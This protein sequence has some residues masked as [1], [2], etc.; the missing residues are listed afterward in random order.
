MTTDV[1]AV[2]DEL[3]GLPAGEF[4]AARDRAAAVA[5]Q[6]GDRELAATIKKLRRPTATAWAANQLVRARLT[7]WPACSTSAPPCG[8]AQA[9]LAADDLRRLTQ[10]GQHLVSDLARQARQAAGDA[11]QA[12][13][14]GG[15][16][17]ARRD[18]P[19]RPGRP[20]GERC[21]PVRASDH[22]RCSI[23]DSARWT[24][25]TRW[26]LARDA[27]RRCRWHRRP[28]ARLPPSRCP[29]RSPP[30]RSRIEPKRRCGGPRRRSQ[31]PSA[32]RM[33]IGGWPSRPWTGRKRCASASVSSTKS[34]SSCGPRT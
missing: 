13:E 34:A 17:G 12:V 33:S 11:G 4:T 28:P 5:R 18:P 21:G 19:R 30:R 7:R 29:P 20:G 32:R 3:Y 2:A 9:N 22:G 10:E 23:P 14:R 27:G 26:L 1:G 8:E 16:A 25:P 24:S 6:A 31:T 15:R